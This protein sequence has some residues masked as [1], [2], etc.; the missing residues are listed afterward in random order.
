MWGRNPLEYGEMLQGRGLEHTTSRPYQ[1][2]PDDFERWVN[3]FAKSPTA[4]I[5]MESTDDYTSF[6]KVETDLARLIPGTERM[7]AFYSMKLGFCAPGVPAQFLY[8]VKHLWEQYKIAN[9]IAPLLPLGMQYSMSKE[10]YF[11]NQ[12]TGLDVYRTFLDEHIKLIGYDNP[13]VRC[14]SWYEVYL[15]AVEMVAALPE[16][17]GSRLR[18]EDLEEIRVRPGIGLSIGNMPLTQV[19]GLKGV[20]ESVFDLR[21]AI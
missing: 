12:Y 15:P 16:C 5:V 13:I 11:G 18:P 1:A 6:F 10:G 20:C 3:I 19:G 7:E 14:G 8:V 17:I 4:N 2:S 21:G 9:L